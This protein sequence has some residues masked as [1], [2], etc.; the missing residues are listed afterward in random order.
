MFSGRFIIYQT[1]V[2]KYTYGINYPCC[3]VNFT[4]AATWT[5]LLNDFFSWLDPLSNWQVMC[6]FAVQI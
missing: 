4:P 1:T 2:L 3:S 5:G 6:Y